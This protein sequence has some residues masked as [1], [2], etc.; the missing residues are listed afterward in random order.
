ME[1]EAPVTRTTS[2]NVFNNDATAIAAL[3]GIYTKLGKQYTGTFATGI[4]SISLRCGLSADEFTLYGGADD[5]L[6]AYYQN[7]LSMASN[8]GSE[9]W[10][11]LYNYIFMC[12][13]VLEGLNESK[14][15]NSKISQQ[16]IGEA[17]FMRAFFYFYLVNLFDD[18]PLVTTTDYK[19]NASL[20]RSA[21]V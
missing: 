7:R 5:K 3:T 1:I 19:I 11:E 20:P 9:Y 8:S 10:S 6:T 14:S 17:K 12:N 21:S 16:L 4:S 18:V 15:L 13:S 2:G